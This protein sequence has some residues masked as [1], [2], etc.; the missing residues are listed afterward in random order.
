M[1]IRITAGLSGTANINK[2]LVI[3]GLTGTVA[4]VTPLN[5][6]AMT[7]EGPTGTSTITVPVIA[8][9]D[10]PLIA[11]NGLSY[12]FT[13]GATPV[14]ILAGLRVSDIDSTMLSGARIVIGTG[15]DASDL[16]SVTL[17]SGSGLTTSYAGG[18]LTIAGNASLASYQSVLRTVAFSNSSDNPSTAARQISVTVT[19]NSHDAS[20]Q[21]SLASSRTVAVV[22]VN[23]APTFAKIGGN[24]PSAT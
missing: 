10:A 21:N 2:N 13:E 14:E 5:G 23:D 20:T 24:L 12:S 19:D 11:P 9:N 8:V 22:G 3:L 6:S 1:V 15:L 18:V 7:A 17:P 16:L 4:T